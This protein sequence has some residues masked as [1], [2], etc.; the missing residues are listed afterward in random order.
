M[1]RAY[2]GFCRDRML[3]WCDQNDVKY[4]IGIARNCRLLEHNAPL[5]QRAEEEFN[6]SGKKQR[7]F[8]AFD[9]AA[10]TWR[11]A[12]LGDRQGRAHGQ[13][14]EPALHRHQCR[15]RRAEDL[16][17]ALLRPGGNGESG[18]RVMWCTTLCLVVYPPWPWF[19]VHEGV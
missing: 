16:R 4:V 2:S 7:L 17:P 1:I 19:N 15:R 12:A 11:G 5:M 9:Y 18:E 13:G 8:T 10:L 14:S 3:T 6:S